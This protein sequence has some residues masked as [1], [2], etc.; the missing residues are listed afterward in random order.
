[1]LSNG[2]T[3][4]DSITDFHAYVDA[5]SE[6][7]MKAFGF[8]EHGNLFGWLKKKEYIESKGM[9]YIH[10]IEAYL[11][12]DDEDKCKIY[13]ATFDTDYSETFF[14]DKKEKDIKKIRL[15]FKDYVLQGSKGFAVIDDETSER[16]DRADPCRHNKNRVRQNERQLPRCFDGKELRWC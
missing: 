5:A 13:H 2:V 1:M 3:N 10:G 4:I 7:G 12:D 14:P 16:E 15:K 11:T 9:K 8:S 6:L